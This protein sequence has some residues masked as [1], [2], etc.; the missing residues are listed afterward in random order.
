MAVATGSILLDIIERERARKHIR[1]DK[2]VFE[3]AAYRTIDIFTAFVCIKK[4][5]TN[6]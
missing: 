2:S 5:H 3:V 4:I 1:K 6:T